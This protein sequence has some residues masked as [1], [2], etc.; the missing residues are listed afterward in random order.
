MLVCPPVARRGRVAVHRDSV[1]QRHVAGTWSPPKPG[2]RESVPGGTPQ[3]WTTTDPAGEDGW[4]RN[5]AFGGGYAYVPVT[6]PAT[7]VWIL[8]AQGHTSVTLGDGSLRTGDPYANG[9][10]RVPV[11]LTQGRNDFLF[12]C[13]RGRLKVRFFPP[14]AALFF[15]RA[16]R[17][18]PTLQAGESADTWGAIVLAN[19]VTAASGTGLVIRAQIGRNGPITSEPVPSLLPL[20]VRKIAFRITTGPPRVGHQSYPLRVWLAT[21][22]SPLEAPPLAE[23]QMR[24]DAVAGTQVQRRTFRSRIDGSVQYYAVRPQRGAGATPG[25]KPALFLSLHGA[26]V[27]AHGQANAYSA[28]NWGHVI[29]ATNRRPFGFDWEDWGRVDAM[30]V[31]AHAK[32]AF[33]HDPQRV[34]LTGHS[35]GGHGTWSIGALFP[36]QFAALGPSAGWISFA[37]YGGGR[38][39]EAI[40]DPVLRLVERAGTASDTPQF[41]RNY[42]HLG[43]Y[44]LHGADDDNVPASQARAMIQ[45]IKPF[46]DDYR[47][48]EEPGKKHWWDNNPD[49][50]GAGCLDWAPM[51]DFFARRARP[52]PGRPLHVEFHTP[53][54]Y[55]SPSCYWVT[56]EQQQRANAHS[57]V[58]LQAWPLSRQLKGTTHNVARLALRCGDLDSTDLHSPFAITIDDTTLAVTPT[59]GFMFLERLESGEWRVPTARGER[60]HRGAGPNPNPIV[61]G[62]LVW[63]QKGPHRY[64]PFKTAFDNNA[65]LVYGTQGSDAENAWALAKARYDSEQFWYR[66][67]GSFDVIPDTDF[68]PEGHAD[69]NVIC[70]GNFETNAALAWLIAGAPFRA[71]AGILKVGP[72]TLTGGD[73]AL[74]ACYPRTGSDT[75]LVGIVGGTGIAGMRL[76]DRVPIFVSGVSIPDFMAFTAETLQT[77]GA[78]VQAAG[79]FGNDWSVANGEFAFRE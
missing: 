78:G 41:I 7:G 23:A 13:S 10:V 32:A 50:P 63:A 58:N 69:R 11:L 45:H 33:P 44:I 72:K 38:T 28:K 59:L 60:S 75:A 34:Y 21:A 65:I 26:G 67:N 8:H 42:R 37:T 19:A 68:S 24:L 40:E 66:G 47:Y 74:L 18:L 77:G 43:I 53:S 20:S 76:T 39:S 14:P 56:I 36:D 73:V 27:E 4:W 29:A 46:H 1:E 62:A 70:Y 61:P 5:D 79:Y 31:L 30:E 9:W 48:H 2:D 52:R 6:V 57:S 54:P 3:R 25:D 49:E 55:I 51:Y 12:R 16:D 17:T 22:G 64:G 35:M 71:G 15:T